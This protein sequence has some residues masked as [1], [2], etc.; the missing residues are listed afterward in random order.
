MQRWIWKSLFNICCLRKK[1]DRRPRNL[2]NDFE[3][4]KEK[5][6]QTAGALKYCESPKLKAYGYKRINFISHRYFMLF[7]LEGELVIVDNIF[8]IYRTMKTK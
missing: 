7:R 2:L 8:M 6:E 4:T 5:L 3:L 1:A